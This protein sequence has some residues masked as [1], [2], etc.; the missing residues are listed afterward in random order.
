VQADGVYPYNMC[1][2]QGFPAALKSAT[3]FPFGVWFANA[4]TVYVADE[5]NGDQ[6]ADP[7]KLVAVT[8]DLAA[9]TPPAESFTTVRAAGFGQVLRGVSFTPGTETASH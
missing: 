7:N 6:G 5:G 3:S 8:D 2:L 1:V 9:V 4:S